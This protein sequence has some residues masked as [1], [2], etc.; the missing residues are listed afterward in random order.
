MDL[1]ENQSYLAER[2][3]RSPAAINQNLVELDGVTEAYKVLLEHD[4]LG[5]VS[6][7][8]PAL[9][10]GMLVVY[11]PGKIIKPNLPGS[12][13]FAYASKNDG[14][15]GKSTYPGRQ[16]WRI[17]IHGKAYRLA[18]RIPGPR[19]AYEYWLGICPT[20]ENSIKAGSFLLV[21]GLELIE[22]IGE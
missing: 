21:D 12:K 4:K 5:L 17:R 6:V 2:L 14:F 20:S 3:R 19:N 18:E 10:L 1:I 7:T 13:L 15:S 16:L 8:Y 22:R 9:P 11:E